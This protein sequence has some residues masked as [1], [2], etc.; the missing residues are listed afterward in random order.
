[1]RTGSALKPHEGRAHARRR[2]HHF[3]GLEALENFFPQDLQLHL[4]QAVAHAAVDAEAEGQML[5]R[6]RAVDDEVVRAFDRGFIAVARQVPHRDLVALLDRLAGQLGV[7]HAGAAHVGQR[8][9]PAD[10]LGHQ[11]V[12]QFLLRAQLGPFGRVVVHRDQA[13]GHAVARGVVAADDQQH[14]VAH[15]LDRRHV[16]R[17]RAMRQHRHQVAGGFGVHAL[18]PQTGEVG[19]HLAQFG[20]AL[21]RVERI[22]IDALVHRGHVG[23]P[24]QQ[25]PVFE[26]KVE[27][28]GQHQ[29]GQFDRHLVHPVEGLIARQSVEHLLRAFADQR[30]HVR[31]VARRD[32]GLHGLALFV[33]HRRFHGDEHRQLLFR[34]RVEQRD[35]TVVPGRREDRRMRVHMHDVGIAR[36]RPV[37]PGPG[38]DGVVH[39]VVTAQ[40][41][42]VRQLHAVGEKLQ[43]GRIDL[44]QR[45]VRGFRARG[46][47][48]FG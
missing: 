32:D 41:F 47:Q 20:H 19:Q 44:L 40:A 22:R 6:S 45:H 2:A 37:R 24:G 17:G 43:R 11:A 16:A 46:G 9:L 35:A 30:F 10:D 26:R 36:D 28:R 34:R 12:H 27:Q 31:Q 3:D 48:Q 5:A 8:C 29:R 1:M 23:P 15:V 21:P 39:R 42:E 38:A 4:R 13:A 25:P 33:M 14:Q 7:L 18:V